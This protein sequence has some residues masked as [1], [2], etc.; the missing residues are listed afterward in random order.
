[1]VMANKK[2]LV[3]YKKSIAG[4]RETYSENRDAYMVEM[5]TQAPHLFKIGLPKECLS[6]ILNF[7]KGVRDPH[8][9]K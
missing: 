8:L 7:L 3:G 4:A 9:V 1:M 2:Q 6:I 5:K